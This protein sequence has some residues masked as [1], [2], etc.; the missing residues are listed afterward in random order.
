MSAQ[1]QLARSPAPHGYAQRPASPAPVAQLAPMAA[2][3][4]YGPGGVPVRMQEASPDTDAAHGVVQRVVKKQASGRWYSE[5]DPYTVFPTL[6]KAL[7]YDKILKKSKDAKRRHSRVPTLYTYTHTKPHNQL[8][9]TLQGPHV[10][11]HRLTL[12]ALQDATTLA[13]LEQIEDDQ[14]LSPSDAEDVVMNSEAPKSGYSSQMKP[15]IKRYVDAY[16]KTHK[17]LHKEFKKKPT[18][19]IRAKHRLNKLLN[20][21]PYATYGWKSVNKASQAHIKGKGENVAT[22]TFKDLMDKP[23]GGS[24]A[25]TSGLQSFLDAREDLFNATFP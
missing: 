25:D 14:V 15:R 11:A 4:R 21:D 13:E 10:V 1:S 9:H 20:M 24:I 23:P 12:K 8:G 2:G 22:P 18:S 7:I 3:L 6:A 16:R 17:S 19:L 5:Y